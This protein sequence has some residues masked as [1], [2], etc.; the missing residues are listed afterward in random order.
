MDTSQKSQ[1][2]ISGYEVTS[3]TTSTMQ[4]WLCDCKKMVE[5][6]RNEKNP[7]LRLNNDETNC[8]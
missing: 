2:L 1:V 4:L 6:R 8:G 7:K 3:V 5:Y